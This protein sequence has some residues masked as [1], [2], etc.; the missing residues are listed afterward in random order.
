MGKNVFIEG[1]SVED[2]FDRLHVSVDRAPASLE[3]Y[4]Q[5]PAS[6]R[7]GYESRLF[8]HDT[9]CECEWTKAD[10]E[11]AV[12]LKYES[13]PSKNDL[14]TLAAEIVKSGPSPFEDDWPKSTPKTVIR[15]LEEHDEKKKRWAVR[16]RQIAASLNNS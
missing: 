16:L 14:I 2:F 11:K 6:P 5:M 4:S 8:V 10:K 13:S 12:R 1:T 3:V 15:A 7:Y 9:G